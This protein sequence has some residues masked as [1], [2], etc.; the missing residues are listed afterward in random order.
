MQIQADLNNRLVS[1]DTI[2]DCQASVS[3]GSNVNFTINNAQN[4]MSS[5]ILEFTDQ[6][7]SYNYT[8]DTMPDRTYGQADMDDVTLANFL[9]RPVLIQSFN[10]ATGAPQIYERF[11]PWGNF[12]SE[13]RIANRI[14]HYSLLR[15][16]LKIRVLVNGNQFHY[17]RAIMSYLP[18]P[19]TDYLTTDRAWVAQDI[20]QASQRPH[21]YIDPT[22][23]QGGE[24]ELPFFWYKNA[25]S[26]PDEEWEEMGEMIL[27]TINPLKHANGADDNVTINV[28]AWAEDVSLSAPTAATSDFLTPQ[29]AID[30][31][32]D[33]PI[34]KPAGIVARVANKLTSIPPIAPYARATEIGAGAISKVAGI[35]GYCRPNDI[36]AIKSYKPT[37]MGNMAN[38]NVEDTAIK[39]AVDAKQELTIDPRTTGLSGQ[40]EMS[41]KSIAQRE[42]YLTTFDWEVANDKG[43]DLWKSAVT[44]MLWDVNDT[45]LHLPACCF[46]CMPFQYWRGTL[47][48]RFQI[49]SS[50]FHRGR[51]RVIYDP[52]GADTTEDYTTQYSRIVDIAEEKDFTVSIGWGNQNPYCTS[53]RPGVN[54]VQFGPTYTSPSGPNDSEG[55]RNNGIIGI[56]VV[57]DLTVPNS[58]VDNDVQINVFVSAGDDFEVAAPWTVNLNRLVYYPNVAIPPTGD[59]ASNRFLDVQSEVVQDL[60]AT[61]QPSA[62]TQ[63]ATHEMAASIDDTDETNHVFFGESITSFRPLLKRY[64]YHHTA[65]PPNTDSF[66]WW[67]Y[68]TPAFP[69]PRGAEPM[70]PVHGTYNYSKMTLLN[71]LAPAYTGWRG[72]I[73]WKHLFTQNQM[74]VAGSIEGHYGDAPLLVT[75]NNYFGTGRPYDNRADEIDMSTTPDHLSQQFVNTHNSTFGGTTM[76]SYSQN[77]VLEEE[78]PFYSA[79]RFNPTKITSN[80]N[81]VEFF[82][83][84]Q[85][86]LTIETLS[87]LGTTVPLVHNYVASGE[88]FSLFFFTGA[89][90]MYSVSSLPSPIPPD[91]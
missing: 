38:T 58:T 79:H 7:P 36:S 81:S 39:L 83:V 57:N 10:W 35:L 34:S 78:I 66:A 28:F 26:I 69:F 33:G 40:D 91:P 21:I 43:D 75:R 74:N 50:N 71:F 1:D 8:V 30:E 15:A 90:V 77:S 11:N 53:M 70:A 9:S 16:K 49:V 87:R 45:E 62:P 32:G 64:N 12:F 56:Q 37:Y 46:A 51:I 89:P 55:P 6:N 20:I 25:L 31:Y 47:N 48:F 23:S 42:S 86:S 18:L 67:T 2:L 82:D 54:G 22:Y 59:D 63:T 76:Q 85:G 14:A 17:G 60:E 44:P 84:R 72:G 4:K 29:M 41:I 61:T 65:S 80:A 68:R 13:P 24:L 5:E 19:S 52:Y 73:R 3:A 27:H 88:D